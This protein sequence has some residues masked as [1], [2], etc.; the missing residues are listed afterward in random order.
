M[1]SDSYTL[2]SSI[3]FG[4]THSTTDTKL[5]GLFEIVHAHFDFFL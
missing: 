4:Q 2:H 5:E 3:L 1:K